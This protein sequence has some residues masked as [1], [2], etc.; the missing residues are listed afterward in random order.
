[1]QCAATACTLQASMATL[2][3]S[4][5]ETEP[6][7]QQGVKGLHILLFACRTQVF[8]YGEVGKSCCSRRVVMTN[9]LMQNPV[10]YLLEVSVQHSLHVVII[11][12]RETSLGDIDWNTIC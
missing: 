11:E 8:L 10:A 5:E 3:G 2:S 4:S 1:M 6:K 12:G 7:K 9:M